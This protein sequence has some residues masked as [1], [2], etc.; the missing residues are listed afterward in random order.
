MAGYVKGLPNEKSIRIGKNIK[1]LRKLKGFTQKDIGKFLNLSD[2]AISLYEVGKRIPIKTY[3]VE[4]SKFFC[5]TVEMIENEIITRESLRELMSISWDCF[6]NIFDKSYIRLQS[7][8]ALKNDDFVRASELFDNA[9]IS[10]DYSISILKTIRNRFYKA[11]KES[12]IVAAA[13]NTLMMLYFE[14]NIT[15]IPIPKLVEIAN[16]TIKPSELVVYAKENREKIIKARNAFVSQT[17]EIYDEC[18]L[19]LR[20]NPSTREVSEFYMAL[21]YQA[22]MVV[23]D[24]DELLESIVASGLYMLWEFSKLENR[25]CERFLKTI[26]DESKS[27]EKF[28]KSVE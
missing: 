13:A 2:G 16:E 23:S 28:V 18:L 5:V 27:V 10:G 14:F 20:T 21:R 11:F 17:E 9:W 7:P 19:A 24:D 25:Y 26:C 22:G 1:M 15:G 8:A 4:L 6:S 12:N 3:L